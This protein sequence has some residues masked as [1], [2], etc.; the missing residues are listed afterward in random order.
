MPF[1]ELLQRLEA[2][3]YRAYIPR[4]DRD[5]SVTVG[6]RML[7]L[8]HVLKEDNGVY[9]LNEKELELL[10]YYA[11]SIEHLV[12]SLTPTQADTDSTNLTNLNKEKL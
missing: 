6:V 7:T 9:K 4:A 12:E 1:F 10:Q 3:G 5:Y 8:R 11:N 2:A